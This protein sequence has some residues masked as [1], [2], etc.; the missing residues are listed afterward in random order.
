ML[1]PF[2]PRNRGVQGLAEASI[3]GEWHFGG[4]RGAL[5]A[6]SQPC[7]ESMPPEL[8]KALRAVLAYLEDKSLVTEIHS[9]PGYC[10]FL[11]SGSESTTF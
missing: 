2:H 6:M 8:W 10:L 4:T 11:S 1:I 5:L 3:K 7:L 9:C